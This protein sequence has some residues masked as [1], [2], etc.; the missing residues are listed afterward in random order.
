MLAVTNPSNE[1]FRR[2]MKSLLQ[3]LQSRISKRRSLISDAESLVQ[4]HYERKRS[5]GSSMLSPYALQQA[6]D[7]IKVSTKS[8]QLDKKLFANLLSQER[9]K[10]EGYFRSSYKPAEKLM[11]SGETFKIINADVQRQLS[12]LGNRLGVSLTCPGKVT[13]K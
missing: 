10:F 12:E 3:E 4:R 11:T 7:T 5:L 9:N 6:K 8:Q 2:T 13:W 1:T